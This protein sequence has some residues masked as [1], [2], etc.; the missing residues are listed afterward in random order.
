M[1][2]VT[3]SLRKQC[4]LSLVICFVPSFLLYCLQGLFVMNLSHTFHQLFPTVHCHFFRKGLQ[5]LVLFTCSDQ[6]SFL[7]NH[8][9]V[10]IFRSALPE[11]FF[12]L[13]LSC[14]TCVEKCLHTFFFLFFY[15][16]VV[17]G[18]NQKVAN[19]IS[20]SPRNRWGSKIGD[21]LS[22]AG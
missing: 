5:S 17:P 9:N 2:Q 4:S 6:F 22:M 10:F 13:P 20:T 12:L 7:S 21:I 16:N 8:E 19:I 15:F 3:E 14:R 18:H 11:V 1:E